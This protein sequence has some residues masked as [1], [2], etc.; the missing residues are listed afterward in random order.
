VI[1]RPA[2]SPSDIQRVVAQTTVALEVRNVVK[3]FGRETTKG[4]PFWKRSVRNPPE[5]TV[6]VDHISLSVRRGEI[7]GLLG[8]NG[9][10]KSTL[11][12]L[13]ST[14]L[15]PD[16]GEIYVFG[17][18]VQ[19][20]ERT[21]RR[22]INRVS[23]EASF[24]KK[25]SALENLMYAARL[26]D[27]PGTYARQRSITILRSL[28]LSE[29][30]LYEPLEH[31]SRGMQ[32]KVAIARGLLTSPVL[33]LLDEPTTGLDPRSK[34]DVQR[35]ILRMREEH[36]TTVFLT[37]HDMDEADRLCDRI[38]IIDNGRIVALDTPQGLKSSL[39]AGSKNGSATMEDVFMALTGK[40]LD[41]DFE[42]SDDFESGDGNEATITGDCS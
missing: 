39:G 13:I 9:S 23:V 17:Y 32:Q 22:L 25:L 10:G 26:Y 37:T 11:I 31:M 7:F 19:R 8:A 40:S 28:G 20:E 2:V 1:A 33:L 12:R 30:R 29:K 5:M 27:L 21:V 41:D 16:S 4:Q 6:A 34:H 24:F 18:D 42:S 35:F 36:D 38:A 3:R 15:I 14:L